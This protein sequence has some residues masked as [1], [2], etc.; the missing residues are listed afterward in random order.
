MSNS[1]TFL[2]ASQMV[3]GSKYLVTAGDKK[4]L[5][6]C[7]MF[8]GDQETRELNWEDPSIDLKT[9]DAVL[10]THAHIDHTGLL[11]RYF[12]L[13]L[14][15][16][17]YCTSATKQLCEL[18]LPDTAR[19]QEQEASYRAERKRSSHQK[20]MA[21][22]TSADAMLCLKHFVAVD[23]EKR[24]E[25]LP[26]VTATW[27]Q[28]G[29][30]IGAGSIS[31]DIGQQR[32]SFSGDLGRYDCPILNDPTPIEFGNLLLIES[33][34]ALRDHPD[35]DTKGELARVIN[36]T[37]KKGGTVLIPSFAVGR[38]QLLLYY[39][40][41]LK[42][43]KLIPDLPVIIDSPMASDATVI[44]KNHPECFDDEALGVI[45][46]GRQP[47]GFSKL[48]FVKETAD[49]IALNSIHEP[50]IIISASGM[51]TGG[52]ILHHMK[53]RIS[54]PEN[55]L[56]FVG[57]QP[58]GGRGH[59]IQNGAD[60]L[61]LFGREYPIR[62]AVETISG[63]SAHADHSELL[64]WINSSKGTPSTVAVVHGETESC[65]GFAK[66][67]HK[68]FGWNAVAPAYGQIIEF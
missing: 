14:N 62:A 45:K 48:A 56:L 54:N 28:A 36:A 64:R 23:F 44:H 20:P 60:S 27:H 39:I 17:V 34:Y 57:H 4:I 1:I 10:L 31:L 29:H 11:P 6:D 63:L 43:A 5:V 7:G 49:S 55:C 67:L 35:A 33:T 2:G 47:F 30:I 9:I 52:R 61:R 42:E 15:C 50:M 24:I 26:G 53:H 41:E 13:G 65:T 32:V 16:P 21:L 46:R 8:Q 38:A 19:L 25:I 66:A 40:R 37:Y 59:W 51:L 12:A 18:L 22:Y 3:T 58:Q 68:D